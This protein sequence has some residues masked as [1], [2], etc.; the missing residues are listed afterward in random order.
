[1]YPSCYDIDINLSNIPDYLIQPKVNKIF[2]RDVD[3]LDYATTDEPIPIATETRDCYSSKCSG[4]DRKV[5][6]DALN[7][8]NN[9]YGMAVFVENEMVTKEGK[10]DGVKEVEPVDFKMNSCGQENSHERGDNILNSDENMDDD[11]ENPHDVH[12]CASN[13]TVLINKSYDNSLYLL[14]QVKILLQYL[15][16]MTCFMKS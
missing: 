13:E 15:S 10:S 7:S 2:L 1:M 3:V 14:L 16:V 5:T 9:D 4:N 6:Q 12:K 11:D 8:I